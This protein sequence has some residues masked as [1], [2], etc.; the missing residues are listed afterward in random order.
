MATVNIEKEAN[1][2]HVA[3]ALDKNESFK[4][5]GIKPIG[6][7]ESPNDQL[8]GLFYY[9]YC[10]YLDMNGIIFTINCTI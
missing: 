8:K 6:N 3:F 5:N 2:H 7:M 4:Q 10:F 1:A 9:I